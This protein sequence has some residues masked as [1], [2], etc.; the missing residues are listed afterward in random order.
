MMRFGRGRLEGDAVG[1][2]DG[3]G[4][5]EAEG[6]VE[7]AGALGGG[8]V[9]DADDLQLLAE[10]LV[11]AHDHV[12]DERP[13]QAVHGPV[14]PLVVGALHQQLLTLLADGD[15]AGDVALEG[16]LGALHGDVGARDRDVDAAGHRDGA[17][18]DSRH[19]RSSPH[20]AEDLAA[21]VALARLA[22]GH[23]PLAGRDHGHAEPAE[24][25]RDLGGLAVDAQARLGH[26]AEAGD[27]A[28]PFGR[29]LHLDRQHAAG[30]LGVVGHLVALDV[31]L[32]V[33]DVGEGF[34]HL[35]ARHADVVVHGDVGVPDA[36]EHVGDGVGHRHR[37]P[38][39]TSWPSSRR[40]SRR[41][42]PSPAG[43][44]GRGRTCGRRSA[45]AHSACTGCR[46][47]P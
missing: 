29:V 15:G 11:H 20:E 44:L 17:L 43:T 27:H 33:E 23:E 36:R 35:G 16:A 3:D 2:V 1:G 18:A 25:P 31:A 30:P 26:P 8:A 34:L 10:L 4:V 24:D 19:V 5:A 22:V 28:S 40:G 7:L 21:H 39:L 6:E 45:G 32:L 41:H 47:A 14:L 38:P 46:R 13:H 42:A 37:S 9:A 12:V